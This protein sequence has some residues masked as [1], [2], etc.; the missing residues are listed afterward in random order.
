MPYLSADIRRGG[1]GGIFIWLRRLHGFGSKTCAAAAGSFRPCTTLPPARYRFAFPA[2]PYLKTSLDSAPP[3][4]ALLAPLRAAC[5]C[6]GDSLLV[7]TACASAASLRV[8]P[9][10]HL[11]LARGSGCFSSRFTLVLCVDIC[12]SSL[13]SG[14]GLLRGSKKPRTSAHAKRE[15]QV[16]IALNTNSAAGVVVCRELLRGAIAVYPT[17]CGSFELCAARSTPG[18]LLGGERGRRGE[19]KAIE[20]E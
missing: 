13:V 2:F 15:H 3:D 14:F 4:C 9:L 6:A 7:S 11:L 16:G 20:L 17:S 19:G 1:G 12:L 8:L 5:G 18:A 10:L